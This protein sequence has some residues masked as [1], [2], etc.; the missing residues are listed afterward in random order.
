VG[1]TSGGT[2]TIEEADW[3]PFDSAQIYSGTW[4]AIGSA[5]AASTFTGGAQVALHLPAPAAYAFVRA[6]ITG[7]ITGGGTISVALRASAS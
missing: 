3:D 7:T 1:T 5:V 2:V 4:S 6:R